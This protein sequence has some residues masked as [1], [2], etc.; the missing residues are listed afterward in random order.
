MPLGT[1]E[2]RWVGQVSSCPVEHTDESCF[3]TLFSRFLV[4]MA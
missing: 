2:S 3:D 4:G 1:V